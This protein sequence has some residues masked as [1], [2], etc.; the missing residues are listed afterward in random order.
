[1]LGP[2]LIIRMRDELTRVPINAAYI[3][4]VRDGIDHLKY[5]PQKLLNMPPFFC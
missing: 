4:I 1:M 2:S 3:I 5:A